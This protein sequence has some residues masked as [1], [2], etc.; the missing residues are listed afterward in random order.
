MALNFK[1]ITYD[2]ISFIK[3]LDSKY[4]CLRKV[5]NNFCENEEVKLEKFGNYI[6][7]ITDG[8]HAGQTFVE[9]GILFLKN[10]SIKDFDISLL[11]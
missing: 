11:Y 8:E 3:R 7:N 2:E 10:S 9:D 4:Y 6:V 1:S 5:L